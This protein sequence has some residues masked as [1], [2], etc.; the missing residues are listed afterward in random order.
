MT[1][2]IYCNIKDVYNRALTH[3]ECSFICDFY[4][5]KVLLF[6]LA[7][8]IETL[9][10][11]LPSLDCYQ[12]EV[13]ISYL[14]SSKTRLID[15]SIFT[16]SDVYKIRGN[17]LYI[18]P[19]D[20]SEYFYNSIKGSGTRYYSGNMMLNFNE[21]SGYSTATAVITDGI[22]IKSMTLRCVNKS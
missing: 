3:T 12:K 16:G 1:K 19:S 8:P 9:A 21:Y 14:D 5:K 6:A 7:F 15:S 10:N 17:E 18:N 2:N 11:N 13:L 22:H 4:M 20:R